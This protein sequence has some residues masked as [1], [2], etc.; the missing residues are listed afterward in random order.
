[1]IRKF[2]EARDWMYYHNLTKD[3]LAIMG[4]CVMVVAVVLAVV[5]NSAMG[6]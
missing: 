4:K 3:R 2:D 5:I 6:C 1:M